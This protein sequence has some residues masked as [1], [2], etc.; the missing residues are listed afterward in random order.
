MTMTDSWQPIESAPK[1]GTDFLAWMF[2]NSMMV[3]HY[4]PVGSKSDEHPWLTADGQTGYHKNAPTHW[5][6]LPEPPTVDGEI[7]IKP[8]EKDGK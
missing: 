8:D 3:I 2:G 4:N 5:R 6:V 7:A 1:D